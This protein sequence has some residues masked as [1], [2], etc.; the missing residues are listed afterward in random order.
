MMSLKYGK[1]GLPVC[2]HS[3]VRPRAAEQRR[4]DDPADAEHRDALQTDR[5]MARASASTPT[6]SPIANGAIVS[7]SPTAIPHTETRPRRT[8]SCVG[9]DLRRPERCSSSAAS[10]NNVIVMSLLELP[11]SINAMPPV[12]PD[13]GE[14]ERE[15]VV[16]STR[17]RGE[18]RAR[19]PI[20]QHTG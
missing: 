20:Q 19:Q 7:F 15:P 11:T 14:R 17:P 3:A 13:D 10:T 12:V 9:R 1:N 6:A 16:A 5:A 4:A 8:A 2:C 18:R